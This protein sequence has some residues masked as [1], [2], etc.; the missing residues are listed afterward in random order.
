MNKIIEGLVINR[1]PFKESSLM[2]NVLSLDGVFSIYARG[3]NKTTSENFSSLSILAYSRF[4]VQEGRQGGLTLLKGSLYESFSN[5]E[6]NLEQYLVLDFILEVLGKFHE[7]LTENFFDTLLF[8]LRNIKKQLNPYLNISYFLTQFLMINGWIP[9]LN[10]CVSCGSKVDLI[11]FD[12]SQGGLI[13]R[14]CF[15]EKKMK[16]IPNEVLLALR[17]LSLVPKEKLIS[18]NFTPIVCQDVL[19]ILYEH[20]YYQTNR[21]LLAIKSL[22]EV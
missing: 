8:T 11:S 2:I 21:E 19:K 3:G 13:C 12:Y 4:E 14:K 9:E 10:Q 20:L 7:T 16:R 22:F 17:Y 6:N 5:L 1:T 15:D 18:L